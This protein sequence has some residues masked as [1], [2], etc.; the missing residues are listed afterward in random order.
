MTNVRNGLMALSGAL[1]LGV[2]QPGFAQTATTP[3]AATPSSTTTAAAAAPVAGMTVKD[4]AGGIVGT[5]TAVTDG[6]VTVKTDKHEVRL[7]VASFTPA[8]GSLLYAM[9]QAQLNAEVEKSATASAAMIKEGASVKGSGGADAGTI[10][11]LDAKTVTLKLP[12]GKAVRV[13]RSGI[14][15]GADGLIVGMTAADL[16]AAAGPAPAASASQTTKARTT[17]KKASSNKK[18]KAKK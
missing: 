9:T 2:S 14:A 5:V 12:S 10:T 4:T 15:A 6:F 17:K 13:P 16:D 18:T 11:A 1:V 3:P 7:P 8:D